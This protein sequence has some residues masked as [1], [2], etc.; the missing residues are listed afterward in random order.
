MCSDVTIADK[1]PVLKDTGEILEDRA[2]SGRMRPWLKKRL[3]TLAVADAYKALGDTGKA[4]R[5]R[6]CGTMLAFNECPADGFKRLKGANFCRARLCPMCAWRRSLK[7]AAEVSKVLHKAAEE[8][9]RWQWVMLTLTQR[10]VPGD[11]LP[12]E[13]TRILHGWAK[14]TKRQEF[15]PVAGWLRT[16]EVT[17]NQRTGEWH[18]HIHALL[19]TRPEYWAGR[20]YV[21]QARWRELW[22]DVMGLEYD[23]SINV[24]KVRPRQSEYD[25]LDAAAREVGKYTVKDTDLVGDGSDVVSRVE[26]L[27]RALKGRHLLAWGGRLKDIAREVA[28][29][30]PEGEEELVHITDEDHGMNCPICGSEM[31][32]HVYRWVRS[33]RD[34]VG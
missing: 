3:G 29:E 22:A 4:A 33:V 21:S 32:E 18:P 34:Y 2:Q 9:P 31:H 8:E 28:P 12:G 1:P 11:V 27:D 24:H 19:W 14:L 16:I 15:R 20:N 6:S 30:V 23:P 25:H 10:N 26:V 5:C 13:I 17:R 7:W